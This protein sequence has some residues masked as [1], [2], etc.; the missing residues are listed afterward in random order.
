MTTKHDLKYGTKDILDDEI[1]DPKQVKVRITT[2]VDE[3]VLM[4]LKDYAKQRGSRYQT[5]LNA[6]LRS[7]FEK[8]EQTTSTRTLSEQR[9]RRIVRDELRKRA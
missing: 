3:D 8:R 1:F 7:F 2:F 5:V 9:I 6:L 4:M